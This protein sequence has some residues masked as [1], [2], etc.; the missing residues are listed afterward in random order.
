MPVTGGI[1]NPRGRRKQYRYISNDD[2]DPYST[3]FE[4]ICNIVNARYVLVDMNSDNVVRGCAASSNTIEISYAKDVN[5]PKTTRNTR[6]KYDLIIT[7]SMINDDLLSINGH[8][9]SMVEPSNVK[10]CKPF[11]FELIWENQHSASKSIIIEP[12]R[13]TLVIPNQKNKR[14]H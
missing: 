10:L 6:S 3:C 13:K 14:K 9:L 12:I 8:Y 7:N 4:L 2:T 1:V 11:V 5:Y